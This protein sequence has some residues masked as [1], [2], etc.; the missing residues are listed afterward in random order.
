[1]KIFDSHFHI[2]DQNF[3]LVPNN[4]Y[5]PDHFGASDYVERVAGLGVFGGAIVSG[6]FQAF[7]QSYLKHALNQLGGSY[8]GVAQ[9]PSSIS[10]DELIELN[11]CGVRAVRFNLKRGCVDDLSAIADL[12]LRVN[13]LF[14]WHAEFYVDASSLAQVAST[15][16][17]LPKIVIDHL[18]L[19]SDSESDLLSLVERGASVKA[20]GF[21]RLDFDPLHRMQQIFEINPEALLFGTDLPSTRAPVPFSERDLEKIK[22]QFESDALRQILWQNAVKLYRPST[23]E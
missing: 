20:T 22:N 1:M 14:D 3:P 4:G 5:L 8:V 11:S 10:D 16:Q 15:V 7:D 18:G 12:A 9:V 17:G 21:G 23:A 2:I 6:S 19:E 13:Q